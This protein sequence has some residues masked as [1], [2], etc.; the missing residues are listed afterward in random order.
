MMI[1]R[2]PP[3]ALHA[4]A[5]ISPKPSNGWRGSFFTIATR[6]ITTISIRPIRM[7]GKKP[8]MNIR[9]ADTSVAAE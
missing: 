1:S 9:A 6:K 8:A 7:P 5:A 4:E 2:M 3:V